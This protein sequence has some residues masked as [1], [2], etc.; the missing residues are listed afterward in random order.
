MVLV[1]THGW[2]E[3]ATLLLEKVDHTRFDF[4]KAMNEACR[5][6]QQDIVE[7]LFKKVDHS[8]FDIKQTLDIACKSR[9]NE[10]LIEMILKNT[11]DS[12]IS[13]TTLK[14]ISDK[15]VVVLE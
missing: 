12:D 8:S 7:L 10:N 6:D 9:L 3:I 14:G 2:D 4:Q 5:N 13:M 15:P 11:T 1:S